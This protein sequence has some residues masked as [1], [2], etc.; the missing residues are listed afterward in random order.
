MGGFR[1]FI[2]AFGVFLFLI[3]TGLT[4]PAI[5]DTDK[6]IE[7]L[8]TALKG[9]EALTDAQVKKLE[10]L[11]GLIRSKVHPNLE[12]AKLILENAAELVGKE[13]YAK[14]I[15]AEVAKL[16]DAT[17]SYQ[18]KAAKGVAELSGVL[19]E[20]LIEADENNVGVDPG[21][22]SLLRNQIYT[23]EAQ[24][25]H[26]AFT[27]YLGHFSTLLSEATQP[28]PT[29]VLR[30]SELTALSDLRVEI[31]K[32]PSA[33]AK[34]PAVVDEMVAR[35]GNV[36][37]GSEVLGKLKMKALRGAIYDVDILAFHN[38]VT[39]YTGSVGKL[40][41]HA[42]TKPIELR[43]SD[44][45]ALLELKGKI[46][47]ALPKDG[48]KT[49]HVYWARWGHVVGAGT[50]CD[51]TPWV[52]GKC[53]KEASCALEA[54]FEK[55]LCGGKDPAP[56]SLSHKKGLKVSYACL[57]PLDRDRAEAEG[58]V[59]KLMGLD[60]GTTILRLVNDKISCE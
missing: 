48:P 21:A 46:E 36:K 13:D 44:L 14:E 1:F 42:K 54:N 58:G 23:L 25:Y 55:Q 52:R 15:D 57:T 24:S 10:A 51:V 56:F 35:L 30:D 47:T 18:F 34:T 28:S 49:I 60:R 22:I 43:N 50:F 32:I 45:T 27:D 6:A 37:S 59:S 4:Q 5:A 29:V 41:E 33:R 39:T 40:L 9:E 8:D 17:L 7:A 16:H 2:N 20:R 19:T 3:F 12:E 11:L 38:A 26:S 31:E 53:A